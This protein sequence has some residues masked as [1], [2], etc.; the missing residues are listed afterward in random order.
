M[1]L[2]QVNVGAGR[3]LTT[4]VENVDVIDSLENMQ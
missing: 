4:A 3:Q 1:L 2:Y